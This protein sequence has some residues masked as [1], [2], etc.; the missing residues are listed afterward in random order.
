MS[1]MQREIIERRLDY[2]FREAEWL[3]QALTHPSA[4][5]SRTAQ[6]AYERLEYLGDAVLELVVSRALFD[7][8]PAADEGQ[9]TQMRAAIV[10]RKH[11]AELSGQLGWGEQLILSAQLEKN[12]GRR[13]LSILAN[14]F[15]SV[16]GAVLMDSDYDTARRVSLRL[17]EQS[18]QGAGNHSTANPKG[19]LQEILQAHSPHSPTY[20]V[21]QLPGM[22]PTFAAKVYWQGSEI[23][24][25]AGSSKHKAEIAAAAAA[26]SSRAYCALIPTP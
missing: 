15:E 7:M 19:E 5:Q 21:E 2:K 4:G 12:G 26:L 24:A 13:T 16:I 11:L 9:L 3:V 22:P 14:T 1:A 20:S 10:S 17:L 6:L 25:G 23:G 18:L 8:Y